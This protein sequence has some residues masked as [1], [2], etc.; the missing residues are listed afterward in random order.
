MG[1]LDMI[2]KATYPVLNRL[3][4]ALDTN[5]KLVYLIVFCLVSLGAVATLVQIIEIF[6]GH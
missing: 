6:R 5:P 1:L 2:D 3:E 4:R